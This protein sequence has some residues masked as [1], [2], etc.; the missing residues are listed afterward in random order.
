M[1]FTIG[2]L[3]AFAIAAASQAQDLV[4]CAYNVESGGADPDI[5]ATR[6]VEHPEVD[7]W[8]LSEVQSADWNSTFE[9][10]LDGTG[11]EFETVLGTTGGGDRL[12]I[13]YDADA[14]ELLGDEELN[15]INVGGN[16][17]APLVGRFR[18]KDT[19][20]EFLVCVNHLYRSRADRRHTQATLL[21]EWA[22]GETLPILMAG[23]FNFDWSVTNGD[24]D[25]DDG[26]DN[27]ISGG[28][29][30]WVRPAEL[31]KTHD[32]NFNS[33]LDFV[34]A[35]N[36]ARAWAG[37][38][39]IVV[40]DGDF[41]DSNQ[42]SDHRPV[43]AEFTF[44]GTEADDCGKAEILALIADLEAQIEALKQLVNDM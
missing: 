39:T 3:L 35:A 25:H 20:T 24:N 28:T 9:T 40:A 15:W 1:R 37:D 6:L 23:D 8:A 7:I 2:L 30:K 11:T 32:S 43:R 22:E 34:F 18:H 31:V 36:G 26:Y 21:R 4:V 29:V 33:V 41:P 13:V 5:V 42:T 12:S 44:V 38:S 27:L 14:L 16:V 17:R 10:A 19:D